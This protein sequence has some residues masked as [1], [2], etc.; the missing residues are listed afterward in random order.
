MS[1]ARYARQLGLTGFGPAAQAKLQHAAVLLIG[2]GGL[3]VPAAT[4]L[5]AMG[6]GRIGLVDDDRVAESNLHRQVAY[7]PAD[8]GARKAEVLA[9]RLR[10]Q[11]PDVHVDVHPARLTLETS[12]GVDFGDYDLVL[13]ASDNFATRYLVND[14]CVFY[15]RPLV[16][17][18]T[19]GFEGQVSVFNL[20]P[21][22]PTYRCLFPEDA[23]NDNI[24][25][26]AVGGVLGVLPGIIGNLQALEAVKVLTGVG[27]P[28]DG[29]VYVFDGLSGRHM[30]LAVAP[31]DGNATIDEGQLTARHASPVEIDAEG[32]AQRLS[33]H[34]HAAAATIV[35]VREPHEVQSV[36]QVHNG[37]LPAAALPAATTF[38]QAPLSAFDA[39]LTAEG[40]RLTGEVCFVCASGQRSLRA[41]RRF[42]RH[43]DSRRG[44]S[45]AGGQS[46]L[47]AAAASAARAPEPST[48]T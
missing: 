5:A 22:R 20:R 25:S 48:P 43:T 13:D 31:V 32:L 9:Q 18:A 4:Y 39:W 40:A 3:G 44:V 33:G 45:V 24:P 26:C 1:D 35:D 30:T 2:A 16:Y 19:Q 10:A 37:A 7:T 47:A 29:R 17:G 41:A 27:E 6:V 42:N 15:A 28:L 38:L 23:A 34:G 14:L 11:N 8:I 12:A 36:H 46:T 21:G